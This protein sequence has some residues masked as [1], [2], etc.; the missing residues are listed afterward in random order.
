MDKLI[1]F[2]ESSDQRDLSLASLV[3]VYQVAITKN[4][5]VLNGK[6]GQRHVTKTSGSCTMLNNEILLLAPLNS[7]IAATKYENIDNY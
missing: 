7:A 6:S 4:R 5:K 1:V 2:V 3:I